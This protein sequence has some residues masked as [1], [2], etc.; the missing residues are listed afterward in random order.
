MDMR[1]LEVERR[2]E[3]K[4]KAIEKICKKEG[5]IVLINSPHGVW[6][7]VLSA[8]YRVY[9]IERLSIDELRVFWDIGDKAF[10][11]YEVSEL[12][13]LPDGY[14]FEDHDAGEEA[15]E[16]KKCFSGVGTYE[17][18]PLKTSSGVRCID[19]RFCEPFFD[20][21]SQCQIYERKNAAGVYF[22]VKK[23][24]FLEAI[25]MPF[26]LPESDLGELGNVIDEM[27]RK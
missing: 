13:C 7:G 17:L 4:I 5:Q 8:L 2:F 25:I 11:K 12:D 10:R 27:R 26:A 16:E 23:G 14:S 15:C 9:G 24:M 19:R 22:A 1:K 18:M 6:L 21:V 3:M 20:T